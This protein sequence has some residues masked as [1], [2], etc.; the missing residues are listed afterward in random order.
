MRF[1]ILILFSYLLGS[2]PFG[3]LIARY[4]GKDLRKI[5]SGNIGATN[6]GRVL[7]KKWGFICLILDSLKGLVPMVIAGFSV[8]DD[9]S[10][11]ALW[12]WLGVGCAAVLGHIYPVYLRFRGGKGVST[13][14]GMV[15]GLFPYYTVAGIV[16]FVVWGCLV[17]LWHYVSLASILAAVVFP[18]SLIVA[19]MTADT[20]TFTNLWPLVLVALVM[21]VLVVVRHAEN[22][23]RLIEGT[24]SKVLEGK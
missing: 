22:I 20:W 5:G 3:L 6:A 12:L 23:R 13:S 7:G 2:V 24:E 16:S 19:V 8:S 21:P 11:G 4:H 18:I 15:L 10:A 1:L 9:P 14:L 17:L